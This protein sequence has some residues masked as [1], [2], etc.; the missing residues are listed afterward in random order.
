MERRRIEVGICL[1]VD[2]APE[3]VIGVGLGRYL[4]RKELERR[5]PPVNLCIAGCRLLDT[6]FRRIGDGIGHAVTQCHHLLPPSLRH[7]GEGCGNTKNAY[8]KF[9]YHRVNHFHHAKT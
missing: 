5:I 8:E 1:R 3:V 7:G 4:R 2:A 9:S 6:D